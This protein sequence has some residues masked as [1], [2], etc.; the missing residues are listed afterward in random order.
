MTLSC[1]R[2]SLRIVR[3]GR[4]AV[5]VRAAFSVVIVEIGLDLLE[6]RVPHH[7]VADIDRR[8]EALII[9]SAM[10]LD[11]DPVQA[12]EHATIDLARIHLVAQ[13]G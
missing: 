6:Q 12:E 13:A 9:R 11:D 10:A 1:S 5:F 7:V 4:A 2:L 8:R 3:S